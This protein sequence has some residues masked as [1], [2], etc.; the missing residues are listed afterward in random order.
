MMTAESGSRN[1]L[2]FGKA[3]AMSSFRLP[4][5]LKMTNASDLPSATWQYQRDL[6][7]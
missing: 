4:I 7:K 2:P 6:Q 1:M 3:T 5:T